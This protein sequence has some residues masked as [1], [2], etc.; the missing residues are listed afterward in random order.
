MMKRRTIELLST[1]AL[2]SLL[3]VVA[4]GARDP[5]WKGQTKIK[6]ASEASCL[7][8][9][10][11]GSRIAVGHSDGR[12]SIWNV[13]S[14]ELVKELN[15]HSKE[16]NS[17]QFILQDG[18]LLTMGDDNRARLWS[19]ADWNEAGVIEG[20]AFSGGASPDGRW[21]AA[22]ASDQAIWLWDLSTLTRGE[23]LT[24][25]G[26][27]GTQN[28]NFTADAKYI[29][30]A[31][32]KPWLLNVK[33]KESLSVVDSGDKK[34]PLKVEQQGNQV[35]ITLGS[36]QDDDAPTHRVIP[37][38]S[39]SLV[40]LG[41]GWYGQTPFVDLWDLDLMKRIGRYKTKDSGTLTSFS[42]DNSLLAVEG[43]EKVTL[44]NISNGKQVGSVK[45]NGIMQFSPKAMELAVTDGDNLIL[46]VP[47]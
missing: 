13:K 21:L 47:K 4:L 18:R 10:A 29:V 20:P 1:V 37:S 23:Q 32:N 19:T 38:R 3:F 41:R 39:G 16:V 11:D 44:W 24:Q 40:A 42:F 30:T 7:A 45:G 31:Y 17:V 43:A 33:T 26:K 5:E 14:G 12:V 22:Q 9:S 35:G 8:Y 36:K 6:L 46:Y 25:P 15:A 28:I 27:G 2:C 34:T